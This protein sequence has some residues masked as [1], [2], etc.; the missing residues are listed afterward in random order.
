MTILKRVMI[1]IKRQPLKVIC[2][3][4]LAILLGTLI[5]A[6]MLIEDT[7]VRVTDSLSTR[8]APVVSITSE[9][10]VIDEMYTNFERSQGYAAHHFPYVGREVIHEIGNI[11]YV[12]DFDYSIFNGGLGIGLLP[13]I[14]QEISEEIRFS[15]G[16]EVWFDMMGVARPEIVYIE[17]GNF[18]LVQGRLFTEEE[19]LN[20]SNLSTFPTLVSDEFARHNNLSI[21]SRFNLYISYFDPPENFPTGL[22]LAELGQIWDVFEP[23]EAFSLWEYE[24][25]VVGI[26]AFTE[27]IPSDFD[28]MMNYQQLVNTFFVPNWIFY[29]R[30]DTTFGIEL[31]NWERVSPEAYSDILEN[32]FGFLIEPYWLLYDIRDMASFAEAAN[33]ILPGLWIVQDLSSTLEHVLIAID[34]FT[35]VSDHFFWLSLGASLLVF[36]LI[37]LLYLRSKNHEIGIYLAL[38]EGKFKIVIQFILEIGLVVGLGMLISI[39]SGRMLSNSL[40]QAL[41]RDEIANQRTPSHGTDWVPANMLEVRGFTPQIDDLIDT[42]AVTLDIETV[43]LFYGVAFLIVLSSISI[44]MIYVLKKPVNRL[45]ASENTQ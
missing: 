31:Q 32:F 30:R 29:E 25:E 39:F 7:I 45:L 8:I 16:E 11:P 5:S 15:F 41:L 24:H 19:I 1:Q 43:L 42:T 40:T 18:D 21:G 34:N 9:N 23:D 3:F 28:G 10:P 37:T 27:E 36:S 13:Y 17:Y 44:P 20:S 35:F 33:E 38:G 4:C 26:F 12:R 22:S 14:H 2:L 6:S